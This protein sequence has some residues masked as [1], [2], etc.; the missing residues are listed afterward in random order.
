MSSRPVRGNAFDFSERGGGLYTDSTYGGPASSLVGKVEQTSNNA[1][2][3]QPLRFSDGE[4]TELPTSVTKD[5][6]LVV[7]TSSTNRKPF[8]LAAYIASMQFSKFASRSDSSSNLSTTSHS[9]K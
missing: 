5:R 3:F 4:P 1:R 6:S 2:H 9:P 7:P 8:D